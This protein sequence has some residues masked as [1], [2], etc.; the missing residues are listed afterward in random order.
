MDP[1][2]KI[3]GQDMIDDNKKGAIYNHQQDDD[4]DDGMPGLG[5]NN[6]SS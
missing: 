2:K 5:F 4:D 6:N 1:N 3:H